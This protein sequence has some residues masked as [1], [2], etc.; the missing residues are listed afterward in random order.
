M[1]Q[2][3]IVPQGGLAPTHVCE[4]ANTVGQLKASEAVAGPATI[5]TAQV[6]W[7]GA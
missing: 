4:Q 6:G 5:S 3:D 7:S 1:D 2:A